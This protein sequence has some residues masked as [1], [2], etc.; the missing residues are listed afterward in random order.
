[1]GM[2]F[3]KEKLNTMGCQEE[4]TQ[5][6]DCDRISQPLGWLWSN[7]NPKCS[8]E[9]EGLESSCMVYLT[10]LH[11]LSVGRPNARELSI[12]STAKILYVNSSERTSHS[13]WESFFKKPNCIQ[14]DAW[15][16]KM[17]N[18]L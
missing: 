9:A 15:I 16:K 3:I 10:S 18:I 17:Y 14:I 11:V 4:T 7:H 2:E 6:H 8:E 1:V 12:L 5:C 13:Y